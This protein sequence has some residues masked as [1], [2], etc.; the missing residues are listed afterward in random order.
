M[1]SFHLFRKQPQGD[2]E[3]LEPL[4]KL[5]RRCIG[6]A[7][8]ASS[9]YLAV[10]ITT[11]ARPSAIPQPQ[12]TSLEVGIG[13]IVLLFAI[14]AIVIW[15]LTESTAFVLSVSKAVSAAS[16]ANAALKSDLLGAAGPDEDPIPIQRG[17]EIRQHR[18]DRHAG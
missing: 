16:A 7:I 12:A 5:R 1:R 18:T 15:L 2:G 4:A 3:E 9:A 13:I 10:V 6:G 17:R 14:V 11:F 8:G